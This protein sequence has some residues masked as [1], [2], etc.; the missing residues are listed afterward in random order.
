M[1]DV[2]GLNAYNRSGPRA[3]KSGSKPRSSSAYQALN[4]LALDDT[5]ASLV[6]TAQALMQAENVIRKA[7]PPILAP[8]CRVAKIDR[9]C[10]T[11][12]VPAAAHATRLR[13]LTPTLLRALESHGWNLNRIEIRVQAGLLAQAHKSPPREVQPLGRKALESF[14]ELQKNVSPGP[15]ADA[16]GRLLTHHRR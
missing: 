15:L 5:G 1:C 12:A 13:Q 16:I 4:W 2:S 10:L 11:L 7:L 3:R 14:E 9:Q 8:S 6:A